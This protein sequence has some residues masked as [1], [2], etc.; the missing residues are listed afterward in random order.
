MDGGMV[1]LFLTSSIS[2]SYQG[3]D[4]PNT[5]VLPYLP[6]EEY[7][8]FSF[9]TLPM[10]LPL[11]ICWDTRSE[12]S[13]RDKPKDDRADKDSQEATEISSFTEPEDQSVLSF[14]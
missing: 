3:T 5:F 8:F 11:R 14:V 4:M 13:T 7:R 2:T 9:S 6:V 1:W 12:V 10:L